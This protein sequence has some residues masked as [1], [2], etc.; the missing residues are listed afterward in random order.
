MKNLKNPILYFIPLALI[1]LSLLIL[2]SLI[3]KEEKQD[4]RSKAQISGSTITVCPNDAK[5]PEGCTFNGGEGIQ[6]AIDSAKDG[7]II[8]LKAGRFAKS[9][10]VEIQGEKFSQCFINT[11]GK[12]I[13]IRGVGFDSLFDSQNDELGTG[14]KDQRRVIVCIAGGKVTLDSV[15]LKQSLNHAIN[16]SN[17]QV[18][19]KNVWTDD[20]DNVP[21]MVRLNSR[22]AFVNNF[23]NGPMN[24][25]DGSRV[26]VINNTFCGGGVNLNL[27]REKSPATIIANNIFSLTN[28]GVYSVSVYGAWGGHCEGQTE[29]IAANQIR[30]NLI[31]RN[32]GREGCDGNEICD[33]PGKVEGDPLYESFPGECA[34]GDAGIVGWAHNYHLKDGSPGKTAGDA[35]IGSEVGMYGGPCADP[36]SGGCLS[37]IDQQL[38]LLAPAAAPTSTLPIVEPNNPPPDANFPPPQELPDAGGVLPTKKISS[39]DESSP[40][41]TY[42]LPPTMGF[43]NPNNPPPRPKDD[44]LTA[45]TPTPTITPAP[46]PLIDVEKTVESVKS[47]WNNFITSVINFT[48]TILP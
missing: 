37:F 46:K 28:G 14:V 19:V 11:K 36:N 21:V 38:E 34:Y 22:V 15:H 23:I 31:W 7:D 39:G 4:I 16:I 1:T 26:V 3:T 47:T 41:I 40:P 17:A 32:K 45:D 10:S 25:D 29:K 24:I 43:T 30:N 18:I 42:Y 2:P 5:E 20:I 8:S 27:C 44:Q 48:K 13:T 33:F 6:Q 12:S 35:S 9:T